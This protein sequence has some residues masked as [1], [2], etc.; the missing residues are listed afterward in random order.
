ML[1]IARRLFLAAL[2]STGAGAVGS[3][4]IFLAEAGAVAAS[5]CITFLEFCT[6]VLKTRVV[7]PDPAPD[8]IRIQ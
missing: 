6:L 3:R 7:D 8:W 4:N 2:R 1:K 5:E